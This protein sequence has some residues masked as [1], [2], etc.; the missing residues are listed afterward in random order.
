MSRIGRIDRVL[1]GVPTRR[2]RAGLPGT[3]A[4]PSW[5]SRLGSGPTPCPA[6]PRTGRF[7][8]T[9]DALIRSRRTGSLQT[10]AREPR[11]DDDVGPAGW[12]G[13]FRPAPGRAPT[14]R[15]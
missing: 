3:P 11:A 12:G 8:Y 10:R 4:D 15:R 5:S 13:M 2:D 14:P 6:Q 7:A 1:H 9:D